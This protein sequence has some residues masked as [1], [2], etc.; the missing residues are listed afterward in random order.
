MKARNAEY[1]PRRFAAVIVRIREPKT[2][3][4]IFKTGKLV[5][6][7]AKSEKQARLAARMYARIVEKVGFEVD[8]QVG[9]FACFRNKHTFP[10]QKKFLPTNFMAPAYD[11]A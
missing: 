2:T 1:N 8:F 5:C 3:A 4:L 11:T 6:T 9:W 10:R 7:G